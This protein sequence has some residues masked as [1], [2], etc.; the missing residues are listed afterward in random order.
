[1][2]DHLVRDTVPGMRGFDE[3]TPNLVEEARRRHDCFPIPAAALGRT[4]TGALLL[5]ANLKTDESI[6]IRIC[7]NGPIGQVIADARAGG[8]VRGYVSNPHV[9]LPLKGGKL[10]VGEA[11]GGGHIHITRFTGLKQPFT[12]TT[13]L[14]SGEIAE[15]ITNYLLASEQ[16]PSSVG[17]GVLVSPDNQVIAAGGFLVQAFPDADDAVL[18]KVE[19]NIRRLAPVTAMVEQ[20]LEAQDILAEVFAG[21]P[22][23]LHEDRSELSFC[24]P[25]NQERIENVLI[26]LGEDELTNMIEEGRAEVRCHF[27]GEYYRFDKQHL[28]ALRT[29][30]AKVK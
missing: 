17:L 15:D 9:D 8:S 18:A 22:L 19:D 10:D 14:V 2:K 21:L 16:T 12:G 29:R 5:A 30:V 20:G 7:G 27:C 13:E 4:M 6:T 11:V 24:C 25:C 28:S 26:G 23:T 1:M 3:I